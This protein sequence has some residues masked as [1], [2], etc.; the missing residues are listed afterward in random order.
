M[1]SPMAEALGPDDLLAAARGKRASF[2][3]ELW[4]F[5]RTHK[6]YWLVPM[7]LVLIALAA[8]VFVGGTGA[9]P[10]VYTLF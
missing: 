5:A 10:F 8:L 9:A 1:L 3:G 2:V 7:L 6:R 4:A